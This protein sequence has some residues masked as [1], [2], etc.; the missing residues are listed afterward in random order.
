M[1]VASP[2]LLKS[3]TFA[4]VTA[5]EI[6]GARMHATVTGN[7][8]FLVETG[9]DGIA[10]CRELLTYF[11][12]NYRESPPVVDTGDDPNRRDERLLDI[13]PADLSQPYDMH[14][15]I[16][17]IVDNGQFLETGKLYAPSIIVGFARLKGHT[18]GIVANNP[19]VDGGILTINTS[20]KAARF[21][22]FCDCYNIPLLFLVDTPGFASTAKDY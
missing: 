19:A 8:D 1:G 11:P 18:V 10:I 12:L 13:V 17:S 4:E 9:E 15:V 20:D 22:R 2:D 21:I 5:E 6:G 14:D 16:S 7:A 3:A